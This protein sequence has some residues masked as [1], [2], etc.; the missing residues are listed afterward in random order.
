MTLTRELRTSVAFILAI[1]FALTAFV[2]GNQR[3]V[4]ADEPLSMAEQINCYINQGA[5]GT[6]N[7][8][9]DYCGG[10]PPGESQDP[11]LAEQIICYVDWRLEQE[12][13]NLPFDPDLD[14]CNMPPPPAPQ[15]D[16]GI[17][18]DAD[19]LVDY[20]ADPGCA[21][22]EDDT[23]SPNPGGQGP[24]CSDLADND[25]DGLIDFPADPGCSDAAD[26]DETNATTT[27][28]AQC[29]DGQDNDGD[30]LVDYPADPGCSSAE[31]DAEADDGGG[32]G[33]GGGGSNDDDGDSSGGGSHRHSSGGSR[34]NNTPGEVLGAQTCPMYL[35]GYIRQGAQ[36][37][38]GEVAKL[39]VFLN[40]FE[41]QALQVTGVYDAPT[42]SAVNAFQAK[43]ASDVLTPWGMQGP[44]GYVYY[45]TQKQINTIYCKFQKNFPLSASQLEEIAYVREVQ[46]TLRAQG[47][48]SAGAQG[49]MIAAPA[50]PA[51]PAVGSVVLPSAKTDKNAATT[52][53]TAA[54]ANAGQGKGWFSKFVDWLFGK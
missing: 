32:G 17:D 23:E 13:P 36:N 1:L 26:N 30:S 37:D 31:D 11:S 21:N 50:K 5:P 24:A 53:Q 10:T 20:P 9:E 48:T 33:G 52:S 16:D 47:V 14:Y 22:A 27:P 19:G 4:H 51:A 49:S 34:S 28:V 35:T 39:Q 7:A 25:G 45:T 41:G 38:A 3:L 6:F 29:Q 12:D 46:P 43:Y 18:N 8:N 54:A 42:L 44:S 2:W 40:Q 15:C